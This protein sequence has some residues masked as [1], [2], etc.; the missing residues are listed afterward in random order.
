MVATLSE[1]RN[2][3]TREQNKVSKQELFDL[4]IN[5]PEESE[6]VRDLATAVASLNTIISTFNDELES[7]K[8]EQ[9]ETSKTVIEIVVENRILKDRL[10]RLESKARFDEQRSRIDNIEIIGVNG[11]DSDEDER[12]AI[13]IFSKIGVVI[14]PNQIS[15][16]HKVPTRRS[17]G[18]KPLIIKFTSRKYKQVVLNA[19]KKLAETVNEGKADKDRVYISEQLAPFNKL[20]F[21]KCL[22]L[23][24]KKN[25]SEEHRIFKYVWTKNGTTF[26]R[27]TDDSDV[28]RVVSVESLQNLGINVSEK[29]LFDTGYYI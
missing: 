3:S 25:N 8:N 22:Q 24:T 14:E 21:H 23:K 5:A 26:M 1:F 20:I 13:D 15:A 16:C 10:C 6:A 29:E 7:I 4:V 18:R 2:L 27:R 17:D 19:R 12:I 11:K 28:V 9:K